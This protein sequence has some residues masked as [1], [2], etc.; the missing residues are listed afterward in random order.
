MRDFRHEENQAGTVSTMEKLLIFTITLHWG[1]RSK[2][3]FISR[4]IDI[5]N[6]LSLEAFG[7]NLRTAVKQALQGFI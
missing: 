6:L 2:A 5:T 7:T 3:L 1:T 4:K